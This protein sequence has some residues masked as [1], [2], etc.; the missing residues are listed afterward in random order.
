[1]WKRLF[2]NKNRIAPVDAGPA[3]EP[4]NDLEAALMRA[5][6]DPAARPAFNRQLL[7]AEL[8]VATPEAPAT[9]SERTVGTGETL[10]LLNVADPQ[11]NPVPAIFTDETRLAD[12]FGAGTGYARLPA[13]ALF[14]MFAQSGAWLNPGLAYGV[15]WT[16]DDLAHLLGKPARRTITK[17][18]N[19]LLGTPKE[20]PEALIRSIAATIADAPAVQEAW[21]ALA[22]WPEGGASWYLDIRSTADPDAIAALLHETLQSGPHEGMPVDLVVHAPDAGPGHGIRLKPEEFH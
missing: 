4:R 7:D 20:R 1:M 12:I 17:D 3:F 8:Y 6:R 22:H 15:L 10:R 2:G 18:T 13:S 16:A 19:I 21:I 5:A 9:P 11:G 14:E